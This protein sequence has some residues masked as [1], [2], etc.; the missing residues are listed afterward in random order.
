MRRSK[1]HPAGDLR[2]TET[3]QRLIVQGK[4]P[5]SELSQGLSL[6]RQMLPVRIA[7]KK[8]GVRN[9]FQPLNLQTDS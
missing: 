9:F 8:R 2:A 5:P 3:R 7:L 4:N 6:L 1:S